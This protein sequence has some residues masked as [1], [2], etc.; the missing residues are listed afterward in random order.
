VGGEGRIVKAPDRVLL[1]HGGGGHLTRRLVE[2]LFLP[3]LRNPHLET[4][5]DSAV[6]PEM[7]PGRPALTTDAFVVDPPIFSGGDLG[8]LSVCGTVN[9]LAMS[10]ARP[11]W[12]TWA[13]ILEEGAEGDLLDTCVRGAAEA[14]REAGVTVVA[15][16]T[17][18]VPRGKGDRLFAV[19]AGLGVVPP[20]RDLSDI[21]IEPGDAIIVSGPIGDHGATVL[22]HRH[23]LTA[24]GLKSDCA[25]LAGL[26]DALLESGAAVRSLHDPT[27]GGVVTV[28]HEVAARSGARVLL[29]EEGVPVRREVTGVCDL[30]GL[31]PLAL[32]CEGRALVWV[33]AD[34]VD[35]ALGAMRSHPLGTESAIIGRMEAG[36][37]GA[38]PVVMHTRVGG[39][40]PLDLLSGL[41]LP[42]IC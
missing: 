5:T 6:L 29:E 27:R 15:G 2:E 35:L 18:V 7:P 1:A 13:L 26:V 12:L 16:D 31:D 11:L 22:A 34:D 36:V 38:P 23:D 40:R 28:C 30:L 32:A 9:D 4:L 17:K 8:C 39:E 14:A 24:S 10:G 25:P 42:R 41:D 21:R 20:G 3:A 37:A 33:A 19:T